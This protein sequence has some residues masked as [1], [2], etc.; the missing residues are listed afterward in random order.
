[1]KRFF[2]TDE[3]LATLFQRVLLATVVAGHGAQ[4]LFGWFGG[5]GF[6]GTVQYFTGSIGIPTAMAVLIIVMETAGMFALA[7]GFLTRLLAAGTSLVM[8]GAIAFEHG[9]VGFFLNWGGVAGRGEGYEFHLLA[10]AL[11]IPLVATGAGAWSL[12]R[13]IARRLAPSAPPSLAAARAA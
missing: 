9:K 10:L 13:R 3:S 8:L 5:Y 1:M 12:D 6:D 7:A 2:D 4:K 11:S